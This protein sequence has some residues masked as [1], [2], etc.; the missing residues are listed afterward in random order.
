VL[1]YLKNKY[2]N[3]Y[4]WCFLRAVNQIAIFELVER[5][6]ITPLALS[7]LKRGWYIL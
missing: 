4:N 2:L 3:N 5:L 1:F 6:Y 7:W